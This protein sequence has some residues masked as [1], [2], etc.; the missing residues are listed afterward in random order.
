MILFEAQRDGKRTVQI[1]S[2]F[3]CPGP[4]H[5]EFGAVHIH[6]NADAYYTGTDVRAPSPISKAGAV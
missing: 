3:P 5:R 1:S 2:L 6:V 4:W